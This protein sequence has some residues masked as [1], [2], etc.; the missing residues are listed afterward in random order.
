MTGL[1]EQYAR[2]AKAVLDVR[3]LRK[4][5]GMQVFAAHRLQR[6]FKFLI[7]TATLI[8]LGRSF[9]LG[10]SEAE[11]AR[12]AGVSRKTATKMRKIL[13]VAKSGGRQLGLQFE[14][15]QMHLWGIE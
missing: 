11:A 12:T 9:I 6:P 13:K 2:E 8:V 10:K 5:F 14:P 4:G 15:E 1:R 7:T 3:S